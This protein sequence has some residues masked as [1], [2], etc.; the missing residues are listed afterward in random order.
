MRTIRKNYVKSRILDKAAT[1]LVMPCF[2]EEDT[3]WRLTCLG[4]ITPQG[5]DSMTSNTQYGEC[6]NNN[7]SENIRFP[8]FYVTSPH[9]SENEVRWKTTTPID[10]N[11]TFV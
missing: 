8:R 1:K 7:L 11:D 6:R 3:K 9:M 5:N 2:N 10:K 4:V